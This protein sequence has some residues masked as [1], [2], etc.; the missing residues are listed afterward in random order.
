[1]LVIARYDEDVSWS[2]PY[3]N[4]VIYNK[5]D[6]STIPNILHPCVRQLPNVGRE[7]HTYLYHIIN[8]YDNLPALTVFT[9]ARYLDHLYQEDFD[10]LFRTKTASTNFTDGRTWGSMLI[11]YD[12]R[13]SSWD[14][15]HTKTKLDE[16]Y[17]QWYE[18]IFNKPFPHNE[19]LVYKGGIFAVSADIIRSYP[20][21][22]YQTL[23]NEV[24]HTRSPEEG[25]F[26]ERTWSKMFA[27]NSKIFY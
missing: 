6:I 23:L 20:K 13:I 4:K 8:N 15:H 18:R 11:G 3:K 12:C 10:N 19:F 2:I 27:Y 17:G 22:F 25:H 7:S 16:C 5:G 26:M 21:S 1:M 14:S 24:N 9:Q